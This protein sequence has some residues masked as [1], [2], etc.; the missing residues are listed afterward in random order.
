VEKR[1]PRDI[2]AL[3]SIFQFVAGFLA[4]AG[5]DASQSFTV[6]LIIEELF[7]N[8]VKYSREGVHPISIQLEQVGRDLVIRLTDFD[9]EP[10][11][12]TRAPEAD[13]TRPARERKI[14]GLG[15]HFVR[16]MADRMSYDYAGRNS[17]ITIVKRLEG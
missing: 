2:G 11:D 6:D 9:V 3:D 10:F 8:M 4:S 14:G 16:Q 15:I 1:F 5:L 17:T 13:T 12:I 7:T